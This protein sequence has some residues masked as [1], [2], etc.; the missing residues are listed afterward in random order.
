MITE[1]LPA[2]WT[3][4]RLRDLHAGGTWSVNPAEHEDETFEYFSIPAYQ[5]GLRA[6]HVK[7]GEILS[8]KLLIPAK[9][10]LFAKLNPRVEK[11]W[12]VESSGDLRR[13]ASTE[14]LPIV[15]EA[16]LDQRFGYYL[17]WSKWV[18]PIA[19][20]LTSGSTPSRQRVE[21]ASFYEIEVPL[22]PMEEQQSIA[23]LLDR[24][25]RSLLAQ[26][27]LLARLQD[28]KDT[29]KRALFTRGLKCESQKESE[30]GPI[31]ASWRVVRL[32]SLG[33]VGNGSTPK[34]SV[35]EYWEGGTYPW[36]TSAKVYD[37][38]IV[39][40]EQFVTEVALRECHLPQVQP[41]AILIA[42]TGQ[43]K[44]LGH[45]AVLAMTATINQHIAY[46]ATDLALAD[47]SFV[48]GYLETQYDYL[49][50][51][52]EGGGSTKGALTCGF[53]RELPM[54]LPTIEEQR[55]ISGVLDAI[56]QKM[57]LHHQK[58]AVLDELFKALLH[59]LMTGKIRVADLDLSALEP[60][61]SAAATAA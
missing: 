21:P 37:R 11:I 20:S 47:P 14:W 55:E 6:Q 15:P 10:L 18:L 24:F 32:G 44:T 3:I 36:L 4:T 43:G 2:G 16:H 7:G 8:Q 19:Q 34:R 49:R 30:I 39:S 61:D 13:L 40:A 46:V 29:A 45:C 52:G 27:D 42:I 35:R 58:R 22:P 54:P 28:V 57:R 17:L 41:G 38:E 5:N 25:Q 59:K 50:Q 12:N 26:D 23:S 31:P 56:D 60:N 51:V 33:R 48:R 9:C 1:A 53:L